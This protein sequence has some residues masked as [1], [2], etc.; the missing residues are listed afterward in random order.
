VSRSFADMLTLITRRKKYFKWFILLVDVF[1]SVEIIAPMSSWLEA[2][3]DAEPDLAARH[4]LRE[5]RWLVRRGP[6]FPEV[7]ARIWRIAHE[8][9][10]P[11]NTLDRWPPFIWMAEMSGEPCDPF[12]IV[13][14]RE[15]RGIGE[16]HYNYLVADIK[17]ARKWEPGDPRLK[18]RQIAGSLAALPPIGPEG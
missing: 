11:S 2:K 15:M 8:P 5:G 7:P 1:R 4:T 14:C 16:D 13:L 6:G 9:G 10:E 18:P 17:W 12:D 3:R